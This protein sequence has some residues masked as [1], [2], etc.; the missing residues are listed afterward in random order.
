MSVYDE[1]IEYLESIPRFAPKTQLDN[2]RAFLKALDSPQNSFKV[3]HVA[4]TNGKGSVSKLLAL[5][6]QEAGY[7][8]GLFISPHLVKMNERISIN[9]TDISDD[10]LVEMFERVKS[11][12]NNLEGKKIEEIDSFSKDEKNEESICH[13]AYFEFLFLMA[14]LYFSEEKCDYVVFETGLGGRLDATNTLI[15]EVSVITSIGMDHMQYLGDTLEDISG[16]KAGIIKS[17]VPVIYNTGEEI[18][19]R[20][21]EKKAAEEGSRAIRVAR[22]D[23]AYKKAEKLWKSSSKPEM[24]PLY[25]YDNGA[26]AY[27]AFRELSLDKAVREKEAEIVKLAFSRFYWP[28]RMQFLGENI[29]IDGAHNED[30]IIKLTESVNDF[31]SRQSRKKIN[32]FFSVSSDKDYDSIIRLLCE[33]LDIEDVYVTE[34]NSVRR[35]AAA[36]LIKVFQSYL[37]KEKH[38]NVVGS[39]DMKRMW[40]LA[41]NELDDE[42]ILLAVGSLYMVGELLDIEKK[43]MFLT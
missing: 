28:G 15:P 16:E 24:I 12:V 10:R 43:D 8:T 21:I 13:P 3:V 1:T 34:I 23:K 19:D 6:L 36:E 40:Q 7:K 4:G 30:A 17:G 33:R 39:T 26:T 25:Q 9:G 29:I 35:E 5:M 11:C 14:V 2:T 37:P 41:K 27:A 38:F 22:G 42:T 32:L 31:I 20:V 18:A